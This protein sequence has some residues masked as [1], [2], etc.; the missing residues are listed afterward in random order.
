MK[1]SVVQN[2]LYWLSCSHALC[3]IV[4]RIVVVVGG[5]LIHRLP[6]ATIS[7]TTVYL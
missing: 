2:C 6:S 7:L 4:D 3:W 5:T 1:R